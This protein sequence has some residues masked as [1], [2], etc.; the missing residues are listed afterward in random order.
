M[1]HTAG[2][3]LLLHWH[4]F[5]NN[6]L[7]IFVCALW[8][9]KLIDGLIDWYDMIGVQAYN[10]CNPLITMVSI[11]LP[12]INLQALAKEQPVRRRADGLDLGIVCLKLAAVA[13]VLAAGSKFTSFHLRQATSTMRDYFEISQYRNV[14]EIVHDQCCYCFCRAS[15]TLH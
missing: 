2:L 15:N 9:C 8:M 11:F 14:D 5:K 6:K 10:L 7:F 3:F 4:S 13:P 1:R 12:A